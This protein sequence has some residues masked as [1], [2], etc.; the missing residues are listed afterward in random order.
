MTSESARNRPCLMRMYIIFLLIPSSYSFLFITHTKI[1]HILRFISLPTFSVLFIYIPGLFSCF[2][3]LTIISALPPAFRLS[4]RE[5]H[6]ETL[7][8]S[9]LHP[10][11]VFFLL[12]SLSPRL[13]HLCFYPHYLFCLL[14]SSS[15]SFFC[16][17]CHL[18]IFVLLQDCPESV[19]IQ[20]NHDACVF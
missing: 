13:S 5:C 17:H 4:F 3:P 1:F 6:A 18:L 20:F 15:F 19:K 14:L 10:S 9:Y 7:P 16:R 12:P 8:S 11:F 2:P